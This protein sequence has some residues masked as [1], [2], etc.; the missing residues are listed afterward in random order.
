MLFKGIIV[1][2][3]I[4]TAIALPHRSHR[5]RHLKRISLKKFVNEDQFSVWNELLDANGNYDYN[6]MV[7]KNGHG[8]GHDLPLKNAYDAQF[9]GEISLGSPP[10]TFTVVFDTGSSNLWVPSKKCSSIACYLHNRYD[11]SRS[12]TYVANGTAF[13]I[14][15]G[16]G[17]MSGVISN[18]LLTI[19][20][21]EIESQDFAES[22]KE[23]G[24]AFI[25]AKFD[26]IMGMGYDTISVE[27]MT[28]PFY[29]MIDQELIDE[30]MFS[31]WLN[32][33]NSGGDRNGGELVFGGWD[34]A[35][36]D[37]KI[38]WH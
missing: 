3:C 35:H 34:D 19:G 10:Q 32:S 2:A 5:N 21:I 18:E 7:L 26:G 30:P 16:S 25:M 29:N 36:I 6:Q 22:I 4:G 9:Y 24:M 14:Q 15:Y 23:P 20:D 11:S 17:S 33:V 31:F 13:D 37:G 8:N 12:E 28:P 1:A 27:H 38:K